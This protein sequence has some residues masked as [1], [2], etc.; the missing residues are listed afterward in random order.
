MR[1]ISGRSCP[2][3]QTPIAGCLAADTSAAKS[4]PLVPV[5]TSRWA[6]VEAIA[7]TSTCVRTAPVYRVD[8]QVARCHREDDRHLGARSG[9][10]LGLVL[11]GKELRHLGS[12][13]A[14]SDDC[15]T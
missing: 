10:F 13:V 7:S 8:L 15:R 5:N 6:A 11:L 9:T 1:Q 14:I 12:V 2:F 3:A 4:L